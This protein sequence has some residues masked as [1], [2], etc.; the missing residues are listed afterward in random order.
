MVFSFTHEPAS[1]S[2]FRFGQEPPCP[3]STINTMH[4]LSL[5]LTTNANEDDVIFSHST[6]DDVPTIFSKEHSYLIHHGINMSRSFIGALAFGMDGIQGFVST[7]LPALEWS[8]IS[9]EQV[10]ALAD[11]GWPLTYDNGKAIF[12]CRNLIKITQIRDI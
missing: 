10:S 8:A 2:N 5:A 1:L 9:E 4:F 7:Q 11:N 6:Y 12:T 3:Y